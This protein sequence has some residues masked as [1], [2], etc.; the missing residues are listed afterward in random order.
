MLPAVVPVV[1]PL[2]VDAECKLMLKMIKIDP[3]TG[4]L[5]KDTD[6][7]NIHEYEGFCEEAFFPP[8]QATAKHQYCAY[9][10]GMVAFKF[11]NP[12]LKNLITPLKRFLTKDDSQQ[13]LQFKNELDL[14]YQGITGRIP[15]TQLA[16]VNKMKHFLIDAHQDQ[17]YQAGLAGK[18]H[19]CFGWEN[20]HK[21]MVCCALKVL[22]VRDETDG[23]FIFYVTESG[24]AKVLA[25]QT[26]ACRAGYC[27]LQM[28]TKNGFS[29]H[30]YPLD[31]EAAD[32]EHKSA[33]TINWAE[34]L[35][36]TLTP[37]NST[38]RAS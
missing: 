26:N 37:M 22:Q 30:G 29:G 3:R 36:V 33:I 13:M 20:V 15:F 11:V 16:P 18:N 34:V 8:E 5:V 24:K 23:D 25:E 35:E 6:I 32:K 14:L 31:N 28:G 4:P 19:F 9:L 1:V 38:R 27:K 17:H 7:G 2:T 21:L 12:E 10:L